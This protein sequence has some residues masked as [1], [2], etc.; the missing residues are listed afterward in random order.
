MAE[1]SR[2]MISGAHIVLYS[3]DADADRAFLRDILGDKFVDAGHGWLIFALPPAE[4]AIHPVAT[5]SA[6]ELFLMCDDIESFVAQ[7]TQRGVLCSAVQRERWGLV[8]GMTLPSGGTLRVYE[9]TH[10]SPLNTT[11]SV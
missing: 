1:Y 6:H 4:L 10:P 5:N 9:P 11:H 3:A 2:H 8:T 7:M